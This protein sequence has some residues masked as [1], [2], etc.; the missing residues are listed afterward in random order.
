MSSLRQK[1]RILNL[2]LMLAAVASGCQPSYDVENRRPKKE[3]GPLPLV[4]VMTFDGVR[5]EEAFGPV[6]SD[7]SPIDIGQHTRVMPYLTGVLPQTGF[8]LGA[9]DEGPAVTLANPMGISMPG[10]QSM[11]M[12]RPTLCV[13]N[14]CSPPTGQN[15]FERVQSYYDLPPESISIYTSWGALCPALDP[16]DAFDAHCGK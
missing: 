14:E 9:P 4:V 2:L 11:F 16:S 7:P 3:P 10:Y 5:P 13:R 6:A 1:P 8:M 15:F 12:G